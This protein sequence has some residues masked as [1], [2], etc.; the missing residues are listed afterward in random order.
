MDSTFLFYSVRE[1]KA[2]TAFRR[3]CISQKCVS[4]TPGVAWYLGGYSD[5]HRSYAFQRD[6][7]SR[8][9]VTP[10]LLATQLRKS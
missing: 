7:A 9:G 5:D 3:E 6:L 8:G 2:T 4:E 10:P 1:K